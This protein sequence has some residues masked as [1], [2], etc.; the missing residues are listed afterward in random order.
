MNRAEVIKAINEKLDNI[1][2]IS[3]AVEYVKEM[4]KFL[5]TMHPSDAYDIVK[6]MTPAKNKRVMVCKKADIKTYQDLQDLMME[7]KKSYQHDNDFAT[8]LTVDKAVSKAY[9][10]TLRMIRANMD[11]EKSRFDKVTSAINRIEERLGL[12]PTDFS[13]EDDDNDS[14]INENEQGFEETSDNVGGSGEAE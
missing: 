6:D 12:E 9:G 3:D 11:I 10:M 1:N 2:E 5:R 7:C 14:T 13:G 8:N 4:V